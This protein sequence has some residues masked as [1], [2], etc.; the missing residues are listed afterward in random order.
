MKKEEGLARYTLAI[1][2]TLRDTVY[3]QTSKSKMQFLQV[4]VLA[5]LIMFASAQCSGTWSP[6]AVPSYLLSWEVSKDGLSVRFNVTVPTTT[7]TWTAVGFSPIP[8][9]VSY[10]N[11]LLKYHTLLK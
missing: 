2:V 6:S 11:I 1:T 5:S 9:M 4:I 3:M 8:S 7:N 10:L